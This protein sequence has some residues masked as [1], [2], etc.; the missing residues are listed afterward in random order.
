MRTIAPKPLLLALPL[1]MV[2]LLA[3]TSRA[4]AQSMTDRPTPSALTTPVAEPALASPRVTLRQRIAEAIAALQ[5]G[6]RTKYGLQRTTARQPS[7]AWARRGA[8]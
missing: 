6:G 3:C 4:S 2:A 5:A 7:L 8:R 1:L